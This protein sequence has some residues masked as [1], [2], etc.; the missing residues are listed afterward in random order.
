V[1]TGQR[2]SLRAPLHLLAT[3]LARAA[4]ANDAT[5]IRFDHGPKPQKCHRSLMMRYS[6][7]SG[8]QRVPGLE[9]TAHFA[10]GASLR[11]E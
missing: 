9:A 8:K 10:N 6:K 5:N 4:A 3:Y 1:A 11:A 7:R 2:R